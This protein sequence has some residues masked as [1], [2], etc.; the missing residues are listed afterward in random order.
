MKLVPKRRFRGFSGEWQCCLFK[1]LLDQSDGIRRGPFGSA[2]KKECFVENSDFVVYEQ[3]NAIYDNYETQYNITEEKYYELSRFKVSAGDFIMSGAGTIGRISRVPKGIKPGVINQALIRLKTDTGRIDSDYFLQWMR[4]ARMQNRLTDANPASAM[5]NLVPMSDVKNWG[6]SAP[7]LLEQQ[8]MGRF[9]SKVDNLITIQ[10]IKLKKLQAIKQAYLHE[11]FPAE[12]ES[13]PKR[14]FEGFT[15]EWKIQELGEIAQITMG[16][17]PSS[18]NYT[19]NPSDHILV[20]GNLDMKNNRVCPRI[21]TKQVTKKANKGDIILT[22][23]APVGDVGKTDYDV[24]LG[25]GVAGI[26]GNEFLFQLL[27]K[28]KIN[29]FWS[30]LSTGSTFDSINSDDIRTTE[31][32]IP[33]IEEQQKIGSFFRKL[34]ER[35]ALQQAKIN[36]LKAMKQAYLHEMFV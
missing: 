18:N 3:Q 10:H 33:S 32:L 13:V 20:Q 16:Q 15:G 25:R 11:M 2:L 4:S 8:K 9:F 17:S 31:V 19:N 36:K 21:W 12:G 23:R 27:I 5:V 26:K 35:I 14:R 22:V 24:V 28:L 30:N 6:V 29:D 34:D 1:D 7:S